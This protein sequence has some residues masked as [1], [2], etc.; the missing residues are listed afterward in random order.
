MFSQSLS[1]NN[2]GTFKFG[3]GGNTATTQANPLGGGGGGGFSFGAS[4]T[5][6]AANKSFTGFGNTTTQAGNFTGLGATAAASGGFGGFG[7][8]TTSQAAGFAGF[9]KTA[10]T[11]STGFGGLGTNT[12]TPS[13]GFGNFGTNT[14][15]QSAGFGGFGTN[16]TTQSAGFST[17]GK[18]TATQSAAFGGF[19]NTSTSQPAGFG[20]FGTTSAQPT[21][22]G[23]FNMSTTSKPTFGTATT[24]SSGFGSF[25]TT[26]PQA[27]GFGGF[28]S[29][30]GSS[31]LQTGF[32]PST[33][34]TSLFGKPSG[35][36]SGFGAGTSALSFGGQTTASNLLGGQG[37]APGVG[38]QAVQGGVPENLLLVAS[39]TCNIFGDERDL[40]LAK[41]NQL[42][43]IWGL[44]KG[45]Y[46]RH[47]P[48][49]EYQRSNPLCIFK[50]VCFSSLPAV[51]ESDGL[52]VLKLNKKEADV[53]AQKQN[54]LDALYTA[55]GKRPLLSVRFVDVRAIGDNASEMTFYIEERA[56]NGVR[57]RYLAREI[58]DHLSR[59][60]FSSQIASLGI[61]DIYPKPIITPQQV[62]DV[63]ENPPLI[64]IPV[65][66]FE[67]LCARFKA[68]QEETK[69]QN[70]ACEQISDELV[71]LQQKQ[72][73]VSARVNQYRRK[74]M[75]LCHRVLKI[76]SKQELINK[77]GF[78]LTE[79]E[80][81]FR[82]RLQG[83]ET[84]FN[85]PNQFKNRLYELM[86]QISM[87]NTT[88]SGPQNLEFKADEETLHTIKRY[89]TNQQKAITALVETFK[90]DLEDINVIEQGWSG[91]SN[92]S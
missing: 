52:V 3:A 35:N 47:A 26:A 53:N 42:Q 37:L 92:K 32:G 33:A 31:A 46:N 78:S 64:P 82:F 72:A 83:M 69:R 28:G 29:L 58:I 76:I 55:L 10:T 4:N 25:G 8:N 49:I 71:K 66:G 24:Q 40:T 41:F 79:E 19:G 63:L 34:T 20:G 85:A 23:G 11:Q 67:E 87:K 91:S 38:Q 2:T 17:F 54:I 14:S 57:K 86:S 51:K 18:P 5:Q 89:L 15:T 50:T 6:N 43:A 21:G 77:S 27:I 16:P 7:T 48:P 74:H 9:G 65:V 36:I 22:F 81:Q 13:T 88:S 73:V 30:G 84:D 39:C 75:E 62:R 60:N 56:L 59:N 45:F 80:D 90:E 44:G 68:Q 12:S 61:V 1:G 70:S